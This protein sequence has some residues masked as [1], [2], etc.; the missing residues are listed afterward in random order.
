VEGIVSAAV[1]YEHEWTH[2]HEF[3]QDFDADVPAHTTLWFCHE[4]AVIRDTGDFTATLGNTTWHLTGV[5]FDSPDLTK[6]AVADHYFPVQEPYPNPQPA[7]YCTDAHAAHSVH[8]NKV[9]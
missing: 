3:S 9:S 2:E 4:A 7:G 8:W 1:S 6:D 5:S